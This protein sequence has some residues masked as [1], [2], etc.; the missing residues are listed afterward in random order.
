MLN[1][2]L[3]SRLK[4][5][6]AFETDNESALNSNIGKWGDPNAQH[7]S[8]CRR[9]FPRLDMCGSSIDRF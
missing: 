6:E 9:W 5:F 7:V 4:L 2:E 3:G 8:N 1:H